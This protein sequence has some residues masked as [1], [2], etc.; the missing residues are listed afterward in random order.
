VIKSERGVSFDFQDADLRLVMTA[1]AQV[2]GLNVVYSQ[3][4]TRTVTLRTGQPVPLADV[5]KLFESVARANDLEIIEEGGLLRLVSTAGGAAEPR[6]VPGPGSRTTPQGTRLFVEQM[7]FADASRVAETLQSLYGMGGRA[8]YADE[9]GPEPLSEQLRRQ[10]LA[11]YQPPPSGPP[12]GPV[13]RPQTAADSATLAPAELVGPVTIVPDLSANALLIR[14]LTSDYETIHAAVQQLDRRPMQVLIEVLIAE[15][16]R[17]ENTQTGIN[18]RIPFNLGD[19]SVVS[20][21]GASAGDFAL[22]V[23]GLGSVNADVILTALAASGNVSILSRPVVLAQNAEEARILVGDQR[24]FVQVSRSLPTDNDVRDQV[25]QYRNVGTQ[26]SIRPTINSDG[27]VTLS[28]TQEV[29]TATAEVQFGA[30]VI[31][32]RE[33]VTRLSVR[34]GHTVVIGG[35]VDRQT[36][37][38][39]SGVPILKDI[40][41]LGMLFRSSQ[42]RK[43]ASELFIMLTPHVLRSDDDTDR[44]TRE[45]KQLLPGV[46]KMMGDTLTLLRSDTL[47]VVPA[48]SARIQ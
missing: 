19:S 48:D 6:R 7:R 43:I 18:W 40:P 4:P 14:A 30:P 15:V 37:K 31:N 36:D 45:L 20:L 23:F 25:V 9:G 44:A 27:F 28:L 39:N 10:N 3:L 22:K 38:T 41:L 26:L 12:P 35:L 46:E 1:L 5:R 34:D 17:N 24:P 42:T 21:S 11:P 29:S 33:A 32:T 16:R 47:T 13:Q 8:S 2:A